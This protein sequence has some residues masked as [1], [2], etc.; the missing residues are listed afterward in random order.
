VRERGL[1]AHQ[2]HLA[3][4]EP[5]RPG[6][7]TH[8]RARRQRGLP[9]LADLGRRAGQRQDHR[10]RIA[11]DDEARR[12]PDRGDHRRAVRHARLLAHALQRR[13]V[14][15]AAFAQRRLAD[16]LGELRVGPQRRAGEVGDRPRGHVI[17]G[18]AEPAGGHDQLGALGGQVRE[19]G[20]HAIDVVAD[21]E[22]SN[23][24]DALLEH[25]L[26]Q[27]RT[28]AVGDARQQLIAGD[29]DGASHL[30]ASLSSH[31]WPS[32]L[33]YSGGPSW[34]ASN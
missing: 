10:A 13:R 14:V 19:P 26:A 8:H 2:A 31:S 20:A 23:R 11:R 27:P 30:V 12:R 28:V 4:L 25:P 18:R 3:Q 34:P 33:L 17:G 6:E 21:D 32:S 1:A 5:L 7:Q 22:H 24:P 15:P 9:Q 16:Q 29:D